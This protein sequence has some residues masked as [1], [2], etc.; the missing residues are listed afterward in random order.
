MWVLV[1]S[2]DGCSSYTIVQRE[3]SEMQGQ[4]DTGKLRHGSNERDS[5]YPTARSSVIRKIGSVSLCPVGI[6]KNK[7]LHHFIPQIL[8]RRAAAA[9]RRETRP[10]RW[11]P[12]RRIGPH[13]PVVAR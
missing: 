9:T 2:I 7:T 11:R 3:T 10:H 8:V 13:R 4:P 6:A 5:S 12:S 1:R